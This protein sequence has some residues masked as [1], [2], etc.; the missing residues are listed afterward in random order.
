LFFLDY[1]FFPFH[2]YNRFALLF[3]PLD[4][5]CLDS[6]IRLDYFSLCYLYASIQLHA[7]TVWAQQNARGEKKCAAE[8]FETSP[9][10]GAIEYGLQLESALAICKAKKDAISV[11]VKMRAE[12][13]QHN[14]SDSN[15]DGDGVTVLLTPIKTVQKVGPRLGYCYKPSTPLHVVVRK[16]LA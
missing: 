6:R 12:R 8:S 16:L 7:F 5:V 13:K 4:I 2:L 11:S 15:A 1:F 3:V 14:K 9:S 10:P